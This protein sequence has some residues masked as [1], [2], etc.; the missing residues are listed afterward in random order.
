MA[1]WKLTIDS[2]RK[3]NMISILI[4]DNGHLSNILAKMGPYAKVFPVLDI[5]N[6]LC[7]QLLKEIC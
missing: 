1:F 5:A 3:L 7:S 4:D 2:R 6:R